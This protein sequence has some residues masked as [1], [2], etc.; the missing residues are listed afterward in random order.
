MR[1]RN[2]RKGG[3]WAPLADGEAEPPGTASSADL[4]SNSGFS[5]LDRM[6]ALGDQGLSSA[7]SILVVLVI[8]RVYPTAD[9]GHFAI[10]YSV[11]VMSLALSRSYLGT[12]ISMT[13]STGEARRL[14]SGFMGA[15]LILS[16]P[17]AGG[18]FMASFV[19]TGGGVGLLATVALAAP[20][21]CL[22]DLVRFV[23]IASNQPVA[24]LLSDFV[25]F[26]MMT[27]VFFLP[28]H[29][30]PILLI[31]WFGTVV[32]S[33]AVGLAVARLKPI[34]KGSLRRIARW[35]PISASMA[36]GAVL[37]HGS[38]LIVTAAAAF[39]VGP[40]AA[41]ALRGASTLIGPLN[42]I[43]AYVNLALTPTVLRRARSTDF[44]SARRVTLAISLTAICWGVVLFALPDALGEAAL[45]DS[46]AITK[47]IILLTASQYVFLAVAS[48]STLILKVRRR[49]KTLAWQKLVVALVGITL[50]IV[51]C[52][53]LNNVAGAAMG[54]AISGIVSGVLSWTALFRIAKEQNAQ[55]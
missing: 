7:S 21:T 9:F 15:L 26:A 52:A 23:S 39:I 48:G 27:M 51:G 30:G 35:D 40:Q 13:T 28:L 45:G 47:S 41:A 31:L 20:I 3:A 25:W 55:K 49:A 19:L 10:A 6:I 38:Q 42:V 33:F 29:P 18:V 44:A 24:A 54:L 34:F 36:W 12:Q 16:L 14:G 1:A 5:R 46:W 8:A 17:L 32:L 11:L 4:P 53:L 50:S 43:F 2:A 37:A 22:Q